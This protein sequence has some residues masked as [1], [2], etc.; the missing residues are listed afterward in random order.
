M[1]AA[2][3]ARAAETP[4]ASPDVFVALAELYERGHRLPEAATLIRRALEADSEHPR[5]RLVEA[6]LNR[7][8]GSL[9]APERMVRALLCGPAVDESV[10]IGAGYELAANLDR[11]G[12]YDEAMAALGEAKSRQRL[13]AAPL[14]QALEGVQARVQEMERTISTEV[15][16]RWRQPRDQFELPRRHLAFLCGHPRS[17]TTLIEQMLDAHPDIVSAEE[18]HIFHD[19]AYLPLTRGF[20]QNASILDVLESAS[21]GLLL[22]AR[23]NYFRSTE[24]FIHR[25][26]GERLLLDKNPALNVLIPAVIRVFPEAKFVMALRDP[27]DVILS[28]YMQPLALNP[29]SSA[30]LTLETTVAQYLSVM[31][32]WRH[33]LPTLRGQWIEVRYEEVVRE[34]RVVLGN[35]LEFLGLPWDERVLRFMEHARRKPIRSPSYN[36]VVQPLHQRAVGRWMNYRKFLEPYFEQLDPL[37]QELGYARNG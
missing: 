12:R 34:P 35:V 30:Y 17:G 26:L 1:A 37:I 21:P 2:F 18:T 24:L 31:R 3:F 27:R 20:P 14:T 28:C 4:N 25:P 15:I 13:A 23:E 33:L 19:E 10:R 16:N 8:S 32:F 29:V 5:A 36:E 9:E 7:L 22:Q 11:S 6:R